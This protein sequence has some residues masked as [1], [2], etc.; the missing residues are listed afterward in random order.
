MRVHAI[1]TGTARISP[2][3]LAGRVP[4]RTL[5]PMI[6]P[7]WTEPLPIRCWLVEHPEG[8]IL[9]DTGET[10]RVGEPGYLPAW[11]PF[12][13][14]AV[15]EQVR[16]DEELGPALARLGVAPADLRLV[17]LTHLHIDH[18]GGLH[19][20]RGA[21][22]V[23]SARELAIA[24]GPLGPAL[25]YFRRHWPGWFAPRTVTPPRRPYGP[26]PRSLP[27]TAAGDVTLIPTPGHTPGHVSI[28]V[29][30][31]SGPRL[32]FTGDATYAQPLMLAG[33]I[34]GLA[35]IARTAHRTVDRLRALA[36]ER[37]TVV[38]PTHDPDAV[39]RLEALEPAI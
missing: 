19:H 12:F 35:P 33:R 30:P 7:G 26:F 15:R 27:L 20:L 39:R 37:P 5:R 1:Q 38:L 13:R 10:A 11:H 8:P 28:A 18:I 34:D 24:R 6:D 31:P 23:V 29:D 2:S 16:P 22:I 36:A 9:V 21:D 4:G 3:M 32:L 17:V 25:G 14:R